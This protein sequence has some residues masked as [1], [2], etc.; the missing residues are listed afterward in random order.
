MLVH[1]AILFRTVP[2]APRANGRV[3]TVRLTAIKRHFSV[4]L[5]HSLARMWFVRNPRQH[6]KITDSCTQSSP[7][8]SNSVL[9]VVSGKILAKVAAAPAEHKPASQPAA[10]V[11]K[12]C[13]SVQ[14]SR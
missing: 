5:P 14:E 2:Y 13:G 8:D 4:P 9:Q 6:W 12:R 11:D 10:M 3:A 7:S 1:G